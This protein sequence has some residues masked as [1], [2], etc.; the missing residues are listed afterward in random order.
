MSIDTVQ[1]AEANVSPVMV[2]QFVLESMAQS[3]A[4]FPGL[5]S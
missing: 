3:Q 1:V 5:S 2:I 4:V